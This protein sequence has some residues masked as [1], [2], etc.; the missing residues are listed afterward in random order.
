MCNIL[1]KQ[2][3]YHRS[4]RALGFPAQFGLFLWSSGCSRQTIEALHQCSLSVSYPSVLANISS[5]A[6]H[7]IREA[8]EVGSGIHVFCYDNVQISTSIFVE[9]HGT[10]GPSKVTSGTFGLL[11]AIRN[12]NPVHMQLAPIMERFRDVKGLQFNHDICPTDQQLNSIQF[13][14]KIAIIWVL[15]KY[16]PSFKSY[17]TDPSLQ[18]TPHRPMPAGYVT[19]Q[20]P[21]RATT[22]EE[23]TVHE[24]LLYHKDIYLTQLWWACEDLCTFAVPTFSDQLT[25]SRIRSGQ[26]LQA[27]DICPWMRREVFQ[28]GFGIFHLCLNL[29]WA[30][31]HVHHGS[32]A[33]LWENL[34]TLIQANEI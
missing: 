10:S 12:G 3:S 19:K 28:L 34:P 21:L 25:N 5:L 20:F 32:L 23:A 27:R 1:V 31:V 8:V 9:Q 18:N 22:I 2:L 14:L 30:L 15:L 13:Q 11:Y 33:Q 16:C 26:V 29:V 4:G 6:D 7:C 24:N 17:A